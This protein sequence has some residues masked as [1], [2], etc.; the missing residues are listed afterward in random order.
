[1]KVVNG[2]QAIIVAIDNPYI[3]MKVFNDN[4]SIIVAIDK[5]FGLRRN[6]T[7]GRE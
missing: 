3:L 5:R 4:Q 1:M 2:N 7:L 6:T